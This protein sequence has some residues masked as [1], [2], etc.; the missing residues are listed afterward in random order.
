MAKIGY[1][2]VST[3]DQNLDRQIESLEKI[4]VDKLFCDKM[5]GANTKRPQLQNML[6]Y[7][8]EDDVVIVTELDRLGH[9]NQDLTKIMGTI[10]AK[11]A[12]LDILNFPSLRGIEDPNLRQLMNNLILEL[13]K[14]QAESERK[15]I[16]E[17]QRQGIE[18]AKT[19]G[20]YH[21]RKPKYSENSP[22]LQHAFKLYQSGMSDT[23]VSKVTGINRITFKRYREKY[24]ITQSSSCTK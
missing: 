11:G 18:L 20:R 24:G 21:G 6:D 3:R 10:K 19:E 15:R 16:K 9:N 14:Y 17:R 4:K 23:A 13:Y 1:A 12:T 8:R 7:I 2:R 5:S 22:Q